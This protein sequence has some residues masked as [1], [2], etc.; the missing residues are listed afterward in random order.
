MDSASPSVRTQHPPGSWRELVQVAWPLVI[1]AGSFSLMFVADRIF[2]T[3]YSTD[4]LAAAGAAGMLHWTAIALFL[5]T[6]MYVNT[7]VA[8]YEGAKQPERVGAALWQGLYFAIFAGLLVAGAGLLADGIFSRLGHPP[9]IQRLESDYFSLLCYGTPPMLF[10][11]VLACYFS[12][13][14]R[15]MAIMWVNLLSTGVDFVL[16][17][18]L[19]HGWGPFPEWGIRGAA[20]TNAIGASVGVVAYLILMALDADRRRY[21][22]WT[23]RRFDGEL[24]R[25]LLRFG[26]PS[27]FHF[28]ID[29][30]C[31]TLFIQLVGWIGERELAATN[32]AFVLNMLVFVPILGLNTAIMTITGQ[33]IGEGRPDL[34]ARTAWK[35]FGIAEAYTVAFAAAYVLF[36]EWLLTIVRWQADAAEFEPLG[37]YVV[38]L[39]RFV[40]VY[41]VFDVMT[42]TFGAALRGA[43]DTRFVLVFSSL[44]G[45]LLM[46]LPTYVAIVYLGGD[47][48]SAWWAATVFIVTLGTGFFLRFQQG[49][50]KRMRVIE[51]T[52]AEAEAGQLAEAAL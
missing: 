1:S 22:L 39:L 27:G 15:T 41:S 20:I 12:G 29:G 25:R 49:K 52:A 4:A 30:I 18:P 26:L 32:L 21:G 19:I 31:F 23:E 46:V 44:S 48:L 2:L 14:G 10:S 36:P 47:M 51:T 17:Y 40:A 6:A 3:W 37:E 24:F 8:Q 28:L 35:A 16:D 9:G 11:A 43:G 7:F 42:V 50:W 34:A 33:R 38:V 13:R 5:G 45:L